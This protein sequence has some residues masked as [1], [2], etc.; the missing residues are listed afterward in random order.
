MR[1]P[2]GEPV[3]GPEGVDVA[4]IGVLYMRVVSQGSGHQRRLAGTWRAD[5][6][7]LEPWRHG[8]H[9][10]APA[11]SSRGARGH[12]GRRPPSGG[13][14]GGAE[15]RG[16]HGGVA[17]PPGPA[18]KG[19]GAGTADGCVDYIAPVTAT[20]A[21]GPAAQSTNELATENVALLV[22]AATDGDQ[23]SWNELVRRHARLVWSVARAHGLAAA[24]AA[25][26]SQTVWLR[27]VEYL[28]TLREPTR[29][30][31]WLSTAARRESLRVL[32]EQS[33]ETLDSEMVEHMASD[34]AESPEVQV[35][36]ADRARQVWAA[37]RLLPHN[38]QVL[39]RAL[40]ASAEMHYAQI[41]QGLNIPVGSIGPTRQRCIKQLRTALAS[42]TG[43]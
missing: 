29:L 5:G 37:L 25:D 9:G 6:G 11:R 30:P 31:G 22:R 20:P 43:G 4:R 7:G 19:P 15:R 16:D 17:S 42:V 23:R 28:A 12:R 36:A 24:D 41:A 13:A 27:L 26:V 3:V 34:V 38:C 14:G 10:S 33:K 8:G 21:D 1:R 35:L 2:A 32:H 18:P 40:A 39:L